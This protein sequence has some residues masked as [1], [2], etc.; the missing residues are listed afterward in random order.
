MIEEVQLQKLVNLKLPNLNETLFISITELNDKKCDYSPSFLL[1]Y[2]KRA[3]YV[4][5]YYIATIAF[6]RHRMI[7]NKN[8]L[9]SAYLNY[10]S[11]FSRQSNLRLPFIVTTSKHGNILNSLQG[12]R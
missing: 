6:V 11:N 10:Y 3:V 1:D 12:R 4:L 8:I 5:S 7:K 9:Y 2:F